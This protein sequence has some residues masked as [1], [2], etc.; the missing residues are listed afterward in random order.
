M[1]VPSIAPYF[2][3]SRTKITGQI[4]SPSGSVAWIK[5]EPDLRYKALCH[6]CKTHAQKIHS[7]KNRWIRDLNVTAT[8]I[9][10]DCDY[11]KI[12]CAK[13]DGFRIETLEYADVCKRVT[14]RLGQYIYDLCKLMTVKEVAEHLDLDPK[15]VKEI[16]KAFLKEDF[17][18]TDYSGLR[19]LAIDE[20]SVRKGHD[21]LT[22][23]LDYE[24]GR[25]VWVGKD[26]NKETL[27]PFFAGMTPEQ[28]AQIEAVALDMWNPYINCL[29]R[30][31]PDAKLVFD[32]FHLVKEFNKAIDKVRNREYREA[33]EQDKKVIKGSKYMLLKNDENLKPKEVPKL[34]E[35][36]ELNENLSTMYI[37]KDYLKEIWNCTDHI[38]AFVE[39]VKW[40]W[41]AEASGIPEAKKFAKRLF[42][43][44]Y[45]IFNHC[46]YPINTGRLE[47]S[48]NKIKVIKR[49]SY[50]FHDDEYFALKIKQAF[51]GKNRHLFWS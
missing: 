4:I 18:E 19:I 35:L 29:E 1:S 15:T 38:S 17:G 14:K 46:D 8:Q 27:D 25:V 6:E 49:K 45:G 47:G 13:C 12:F 32:L 23:V 31:C 20:I 33:F 48:N 36:L 22:I 39:L 51:P 3:F 10:L 11:R 44:C 50:G 26:R 5:V 34:R 40:R 2:A 16:D 21:Y 30:W 24:T 7:N 37:L 28:R 43:Y 9:Y 41:I 42:R